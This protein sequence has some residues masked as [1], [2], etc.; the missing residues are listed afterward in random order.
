[1]VSIPKVRITRIR[2]GLV[3]EDVRRHQRGIGQQT[4][5]HIVGVLAHLVLEGGDALQLAKVGI[6][7]KEEVELR[8]LREVALEI[9]GSAFGVEAGSQVL[10]QYLTGILIQVARSGMSGQR[11][12]VRHEKVAV[13]LLLQLHEIAEGTEIVAQM[14]VARRADAA[15]HNLT[16]DVISH[17]HRVINE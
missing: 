7:I 2:R 1:M 4:G 12:V 10:H 15:A 9:D 16:L 13:V 3:D 6:H 14:Q 8:G 17:R 11:M 5:I